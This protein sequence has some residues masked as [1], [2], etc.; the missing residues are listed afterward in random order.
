MKLFV[1]L[2][3]VTIVAEI[4]CAQLKTANRESRHPTREPQGLFPDV[5]V[6]SSRTYRSARQSQANNYKFDD[7][8]LTNDKIVP[9]QDKPLVGRPGAL[10]LYEPKTSNVHKKLK[11]IS[12]KLHKK[13]KIGRGNDSSDSHSK[14]QRKEKLETRKHK[15]KSKRK[16]TSSECKICKKEKQR[17]RGKVC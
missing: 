9:R 14:E 4:Y 13:R 10:L 12:K 17:K 7:E 8:L 3:F 16:Q 15:K 1:V 6:R 5:R 2:L 11:K